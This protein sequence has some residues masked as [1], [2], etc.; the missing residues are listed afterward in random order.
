[1]KELLFIACMAIY[2]SNI[3]AQSA[4]TTTISIQATA[5]EI[6]AEEQVTLSVRKTC[7]I[8]D[9]LC[10]DGTAVKREEYAQ[11]GKTAK[12][13]VFW[14]S[15]D[16]THGWAVH[17]QEELYCPW[18]TIMTDLPNLPNVDFDSFKERY[19]DTAGYLNTK[20]I[21]E[22]GDSVM[23]PAAYSVDFENGWYLP[24]ARQVLVLQ[25]EIP[26]LNKSLA[27]IPKANII[28]KAILHQNNIYYAWQCWSSTEIDANFVIGGVELTCLNRL[29]TG[30]YFRTRAVCIFQI[31]KP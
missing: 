10:T 24:A 27:L 5:Q 31:N 2:S 16:E 7:A 23:F 19:A 20:I 9:I 25:L 28:E 21:R 3:L 17:L 29:K 11:S 4:D 22:S 8:G 30:T 13:V 18:S 14:I 12:G 1:M 6:C 15:P 26:E